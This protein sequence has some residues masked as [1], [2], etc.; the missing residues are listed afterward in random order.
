M[1]G[2]QKNLLK[3]VKET[4]ATQEPVSIYE[5]TEKNRGRLEFRKA[6]LF[7]PIDNIPSGWEELNA[8]ISV[9]RTVEKKG[10]TTYQEC[11]YISSL[12]SKD[13][14][15]FGKAIRGHWSIENQLHWVKDV[16]QNED[17]AGIKKGNGIEVLAIFRN[18]AINLTRQFGYDS[19]KQGQIY[20]ASNLKELYNKIQSI[21][22]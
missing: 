16:I 17:N 7:K 4:V 19:I 9:Q 2:N 21:S 18:I 1:K 15:F 3:A 12:T 5:N 14:E 11:F 6:Q 10:K 20:F 13:A 22:T 8:I